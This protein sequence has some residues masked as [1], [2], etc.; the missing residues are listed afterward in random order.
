MTGE[1]TPAASPAEHVEHVGSLVRPPWL[2]GAALGVTRGRLGPDQL[3]LLQ[4]RAVSEALARQAAAGLAVVT[5]GELRRVPLLVA[6]SEDAGS[7]QGGWAGP[8]VPHVHDEELVALGAHGGSRPQPGDGSAGGQA[9]AA[10]GQAGAPAPTVLEEHRFACDHTRRPV[11]ISL[12]GAERA[13]Q[14]LVPLIGGARTHDGFAELVAEVVR[15]ERAL[16][17]G[18][19]ADG[20]RHVQ[21][22]VPGYAGYENPVR[23]AA[24]R[25][26]GIDPLADLQLSIGADNAVVAGTEGVT[27]GLHVCRRGEQGRWR[28]AISN[29]QVAETMMSQL[30]FDRLLL[31]FGYDEPRFEQLRFIPKGLTVVLGLVSTTNDRVETSDE[32]MAR[33]DEASAHIDVDQLAIGPSCGF[34]GAI[35]HRDV[36]ETSQWRKLDALMETAERVWG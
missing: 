30:R 4:D 32:L 23:W 33:I 21:L 2:E 20:C 14:S 1:P 36:S 15:N 27:F 3:R 28:A 11:K 17:S 29:D 24:R 13:A 5:D 25:G 31:D 35:G 12:L 19:V 16:I 6:P 7:W 34:A 10:G 26:H 18:L 9:G 8:L 22:D